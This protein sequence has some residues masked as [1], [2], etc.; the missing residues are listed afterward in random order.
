MPRTVAMVVMAAVMVVGVGACSQQ[1]GPQNPEAMMKAYEELA[2]PG[3]EHEKLQEACGTWKTVT[4]MWMGEDEPTASE[5]NSVIEPILGGLYVREVFHGSV[6]GKKFT[7]WGIYGYDRGQGKYTSVWVDS[8]STSPIM[9]LGTYDKEGKVMTL[10]GAY[11]CPMRG[12]VELKNVIK[13]VSDDEAVMTMY[14]VGWFGQEQK[15]MEI[16]YTRK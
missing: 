3:P 10:T 14:E 12:H 9:M 2:K 7:G 1:M 5:G 13:E 8:M 11:E 6:Q 16:T 15:M 4:K